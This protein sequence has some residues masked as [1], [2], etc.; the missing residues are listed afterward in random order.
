MT[1]SNLTTTLKSSDFL[2]ILRPKSSGNVQDLLIRVSSLG[3]LGGGE[4]GSI[5]GDLADQTDLSGALALKA[6]LADPGITRTTLALTPAGTVDVS[7]T[8]T[9]IQTL[10][11][12][13]AQTFAFVGTPVT[14]RVF[15]IKVTADSTA[16][17]CTIPSVID[18]GTGV[19]RT[20]FTVPASGV[21]QVD[22]RYNGS[23]YE[24]VGFIPVA[25]TDYATPATALA[26]AKAAQLGTHS[27]PDT[28]GGA[29]SWTAPL[30]VVWTNTTTTYSLPAVAGYTGMAVLF[31][32]VGT[33]AITIDPNASEVIV[34][35]GTAQTGG[36]TMT[37]TGAA[38]N[39]VGIYCTGSRWVT[40]G[41]KGTLAAGA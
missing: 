23:A 26:S 20:A 12:T 28:T 35:D 15:S 16:R 2:P 11:I 1:P 36:V 7:V 22:F 33:N 29:I 3:G 4:W 41:F 6:P 17:V 14:G 32:V 19:A 9:R 13:A 27:T 5:T 25:G 10:S 21:V 24:A 39:Y 40:L 18:L 34:R 31:Y 38:G 37:L 8:E 30:Y